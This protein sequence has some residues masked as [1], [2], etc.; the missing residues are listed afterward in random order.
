M[1]A[2]TRHRPFNPT[3]QFLACN[4]RNRPQ[5]AGGEKWKRP[6][7]ARTEESEDALTLEFLLSILNDLAAEDFENLWETAKETSQ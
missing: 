4:S 1:E 6:S 7:A 2:G 3:V 5:V